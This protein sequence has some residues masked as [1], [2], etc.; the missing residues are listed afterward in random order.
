MVCFPY[1]FTLLSNKCGNDHSKLKFVSPTNLHCSQTERDSCCRRKG[2]FPLRIY[3][4]LKR[5]YTDVSGV[6]CLFPLRIYTALKPLSVSCRQSARL[7]PLRIYT[8][9]KLFKHRHSC[10]NCL[11]PLRIYTAL[12]PL[13]LH[14]FIEHG[15]FPLRIYTALKRKMQSSTNTH[16][17]FPLRIYTALKPQTSNCPR[18]ISAKYLCNIPSVFRKH[19][20]FNIKYIDLHP[21]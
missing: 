13:F 10:C 14:H 20:Y 5:Y 1:E 4:A 16:S 18:K 8:A 12:K 11:F 17:L 19:F 6:K 21:L 9:L 3:T 2:L 15:L 7:F